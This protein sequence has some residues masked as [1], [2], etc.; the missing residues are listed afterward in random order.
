MKKI[1]NLFYILGFYLLSFNSASAHIKWFVDEEEVISNKRGLNPFFNVESSEVWIWMGISLLVVLV[2][3]LIDKFVKEPSGLNNFANRN[4]KVINR[5]AQVVLGI[6]LITVSFVWKIILVPTI[7]INNTVTFGLSLVQALVGV[8]FVLN[9][10]P[11]IASILLVFFCFGVGIYGGWVTF[12]E[13]LILISLAIYFFIKNSKSNIN[14]PVWDKYSLFIVRLG[15][16][17][18]LIVLAFTEKLAYP[19]LSLAFLETHNWNF[20][21]AIF[22]WFT[23]ELFVLSVGFAEIIFGILFVLGYM[24]RITTI[25]IA[26]FFACSVTTMLIQF[27]IWEVEDLVVY[28]AAIIFLFFGAGEIK[29][30]K[31]NAKHF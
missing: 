1:K 22:P 23:N 2:Y 17:L 30:K 18:S 16:G 27:G 19:E 5:I 9:I 4:A 15:V 11:R 29:F 24:T 26:I 8:M 21:Q 25:L 3:G 7:D 10:Y 6:F 28:S 12:L 14:Y 13:N 20:M 31:L